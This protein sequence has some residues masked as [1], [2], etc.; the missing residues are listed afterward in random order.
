MN[1]HQPGEVK[2]QLDGAAETF[3]FFDG[4]GVGSQ[5]RGD[6]AS[7]GAVPLG[8]HG[9]K[10]L[11][12]NAKEGPAAAHAGLSASQGTL[13]IDKLAQLQLEDAGAG[14]P[15]HKEETYTK[16]PDQ[17][18][19]KFG[20]TAS[21]RHPRSFPLGAK[22]PLPRGVPFTCRNI[23]KASVKPKRCKAAILL[24]GLLKASNSLEDHCRLMRSCIPQVVQ[25]SAAG[26]SCRSRRLH[27][28]RG[29]DAKYSPARAG[30]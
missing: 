20:P 27:L 26:W 15:L 17:T 24:L 23:V 4:E 2:R 18:L 21:R 12:A 13:V 9:L 29:A 1:A 8:D 14:H 11:Q 19:P 6:D 7:E 10:M 25:G 30:R 3:R 16:E 28:P 22:P 5:H